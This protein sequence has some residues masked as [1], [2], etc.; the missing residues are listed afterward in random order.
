MRLIVKPYIVAIGSL[1]L[2]GGILHAWWT[3]T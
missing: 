3:E 1:L 2:D